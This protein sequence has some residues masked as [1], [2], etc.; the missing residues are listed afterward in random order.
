MPD[1]PDAREKRSY[2]G[3]CDADPWFRFRRGKSMAGL[4]CGPEIASIRRCDSFSARHVRQAHL[5]AAGGSGRDPVQLSLGP[6]MMSLGSRREPSEQASRMR[7]SSSTDAGEWTSVCPRLAEPSG[8]VAET[9]IQYLTTLLSDVS[10]CSNLNKRSR[11]SPL[12]LNRSLAHP[13]QPS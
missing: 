7:R 12:L 1:R 10:L 3:R 6:P 8:A 5:E 11:E 13:R 4:S 9:S 2:E